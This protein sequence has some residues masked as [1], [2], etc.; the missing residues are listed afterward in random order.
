MYWKLIPSAFLFVMMLSADAKE[1]IN[2]YVYLQQSHYNLKSVDKLPYY[3]AFRK[4]DQLKSEH[5]GSH[6]MVLSND[7]HQQLGSKNG[8][9][10]W[11]EV[12]LVFNKR[13]VRRHSPLQ[14]TSDFSQ[15]TFYKH[16][17][18]T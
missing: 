7:I 2:E 5:L 4:N 13:E 8:R 17:P 14:G 18:L 6:W 16:S 10:D 3:L 9:Y 11:I 15:S 1:T 12:N